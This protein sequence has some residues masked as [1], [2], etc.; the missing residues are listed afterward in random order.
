M[1]VPLR[2]VPPAF[3]GTALHE[4][5]RTALTMNQPNRN[6]FSAVCSWTLPLL[7][8]LLQAN[9][10]SSASLKLKTCP[11][12]PN[13][14]SSQAQDSAHHI[15]PITYA[16]T[17]TEAKRMI[18]DIL[19]STPRTKIVVDEENFIHAEISSSLFGFI[20]DIQFFLDEKEKTIHIHSS[21]RS[22]YWDLGKNRS[23]L[24]EM[25]SRFKEKNKDH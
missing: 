24:E 6:I 21:S 16:V 5:S 19:H 23:R 2:L 1:A 17:K 10:A 25:R 3:K 11:D 22:G 7:F 13:C 9:S 14:V 4:F 12:S 20:D 15:K 18:L 8:F